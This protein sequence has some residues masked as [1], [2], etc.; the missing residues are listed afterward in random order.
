MSQGALYSFCIS[1]EKALAN[2][3]VRFT[4]L[5]LADR[6]EVDSSAVQSGVMKASVFGR[7]YKKILESPGICGRAKVYGEEDVDDLKQGRASDAAGFTPKW[8][9]AAV[10]DA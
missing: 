9:P 3:N 2:T 4:E 7:A 8:K 10:L 6:V 1:A 5:Y